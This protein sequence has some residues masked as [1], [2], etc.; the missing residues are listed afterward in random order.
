VGFSARK[1]LEVREHQVVFLRPRP[2]VIAICTRTYGVRKAEP[3]PKPLLTVPY[4]TALRY[5][6]GSAAVSHDCK[7]GPVETELLAIHLKS[8][9]CI[10]CQM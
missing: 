8:I 3:V 6:D 9:D 5:A 7:L 4:A 1:I 10:G 2:C